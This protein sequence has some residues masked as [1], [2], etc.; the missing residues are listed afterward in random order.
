[1]LIDGGDVSR[2]AP[3]KRARKGMARTFQRLELF[4]L[5]TVRENVLVVIVILFAP[6][7]ILGLLKKWWHK[8]RRRFAPAPAAT[9]TP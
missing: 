1:V 5:L 7:G 3:H 4:S 8:A 6:D 2:L 9:E